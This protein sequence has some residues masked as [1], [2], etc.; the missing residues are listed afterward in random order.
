MHTIGPGL[1]G[2][3][4]ALGLI[5]G[6]LLWGVIDRIRWLR[7]PPSLALSLGCA[8]LVVA[9]GAALWAATRYSD[10][11]VAAAGFG[12][13]WEC[14]PLPARATVCFHDGPAASPSLESASGR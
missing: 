8:C 11:E 1:W 13:G 2:T 6:V 12:P 5:S 14:L 9:T 7:Q 3:T 10:V 4:A